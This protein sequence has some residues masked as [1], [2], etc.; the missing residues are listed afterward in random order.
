M[1]QCNALR[2]IWDT[3]GFEVITELIQERMGIFH[4]GLLE[5]E[6]MEKTSAMQIGYKVLNSLWNDIGNI[7]SYKD[8][9]SFM[10]EENE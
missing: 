7:Y 5:A 9:N 2:N 8:N 4:S 3:E 10:E 1:K 6:N